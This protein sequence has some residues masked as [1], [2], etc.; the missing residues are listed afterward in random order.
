M[1]RHGA[2]GSSPPGA[3]RRQPSGAGIS[4]N[5]MR[6][7]RVRMV[8]GESRGSKVELRKQSRRDGGGSQRLAIE[9]RRDVARLTEKKE[10]RLRFRVGSRDRH[11]EGYNQSKRCMATSSQNVSIAVPTSYGYNHTTRKHKTCIGEKQNS[12]QN[13]TEHQTLHRKNQL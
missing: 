8:G 2:S 3:R 11:P 10:R 13:A 12:P 6:S 7:L 1:P 9:V 4:H 5:G